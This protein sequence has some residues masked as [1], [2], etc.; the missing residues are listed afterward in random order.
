[1][2]DD[3]K[4]FLENNPDRV[5]GSSS[6]LTVGDVDPAAMDSAGEEGSGLPA[7]S[8]QSVRVAGLG[9]SIND[10]YSG[11]IRARARAKKQWKKKVRRAAKGELQKPDSFPV[12]VIYRTYI[13]PGRQPRDA[14]GA[15]AAA[16]IAIDALED[17]GVLPSDD[18]HYV[19]SVTPEAPRRTDALATEIIL[20]ED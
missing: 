19:R 8:V 4:D 9:P 10:A 5:A 3:W 17:L 13:P 2:S 6:P 12:R 20:I 16:K 15:S 7:A 14:D 18:R 1:M 11:T